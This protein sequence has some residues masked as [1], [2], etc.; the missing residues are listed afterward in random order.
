MVDPVSIRVQA[1]P[2]GR[3][4]CCDVLRH[5]GL[6]LL[7]TDTV[8]G[9]AVRADC[10]PA[11]DALFAAKG[12]GDSQPAA[13]LR[14]RDPGWEHLGV[15]PTGAALALA[16]AFWPGALTLLVHTHNPWD[17]R[18]DGGKG[19]LGV[20]VPDHSWLLGLLEEMNEPIAVSSA[21]L[22]GQPAA[23]DLVRLPEP[24]LRA[25]DAVVE[26]GR[27]P[28]E[29]PSAVMDVSGPAP[30]LVREG[31]LGARAMSMVERMLDT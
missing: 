18:I 29:P 13:L 12:R 27:L 25:V 11:L 1:D 14:P 7:P 6:V 9:L 5:G 23:R 31:A 15:E 4:L 2:V 22:S 10:K 28:D 20:R 30:R 19:T 8:Y 24:L 21:N 26:G 16:E 3:R 17:A